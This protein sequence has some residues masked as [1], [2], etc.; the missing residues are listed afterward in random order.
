MQFPFKTK[1]NDNVFRKF[2]SKSL[3]SMELNKS[4]H[5]AALIAP[6]L[7]LLINPPTRSVPTDKDKTL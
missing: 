5:F 7:I 1:V 3:L 2:G 6:R 4:S